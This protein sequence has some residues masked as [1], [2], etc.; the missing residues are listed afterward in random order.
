M[1]LLLVLVG[2][3]VLGLAVLLLRTAFR[4]IVWVVLLAFRL[5]RFLLRML[6][7]PR[8]ALDFVRRIESL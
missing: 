7:A 1:F 5:L 6:F 2:L 8:Q 4:L 3:A